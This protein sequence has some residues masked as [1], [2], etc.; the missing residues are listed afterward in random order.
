[1]SAVR[2]RRAKRKW[3]RSGKGRLTPGPWTRIK[4]LNSLQEKGKGELPM[5]AHTMAGQSKVLHDYTKKDTGGY[6]V[7]NV[8]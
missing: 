7:S 4:Q 2:S 8:L 3:T 5:H 6:K 1:M